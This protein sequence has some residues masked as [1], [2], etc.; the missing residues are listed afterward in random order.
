MALCL[1]ASNSAL[2]GGYIGLGFGTASWD[3]KPL[4]GTYEVDDGTPLRIFGGSRTGQLG[5]EIDFSMSE[6]D[7]YDNFGIIAFSP[8]G[9]ITHMAD[10]LIFSVIGF[11]PLSPTFDLYGKLGL[12]MWSTTVEVEG[13]ELEGD[14]GI[15]LAAGAGLNINVAQNFLIRL[16]AQYLPG[17]GD[18]IDEGDITQF[19]AG[20]A[21]SW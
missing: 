21:Y 8:G 12:N 13:V 3:I 19:T 15:D 2:A 9:K 17:I 18:G 4:L 10:N 14:D 20:G 16:E 6:H 5:W 7:W 11:L 1:V